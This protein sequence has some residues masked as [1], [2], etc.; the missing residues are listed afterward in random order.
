M[1][2]ALP[3]CQHLADDP[4]TC[5]IPVIIL[6]GMEGPDIVRNARAAGCLFFLRK[7]YDPNALLLLTRDALGLIRPGDLSP[8][9]VGD[10]NGLCYTDGFDFVTKCSVSVRPVLGVAGGNQENRKRSTKDWPQ[11]ATY[12]SSDSP[13]QEIVAVARGRRI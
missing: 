10:V 7:P 1:A 11:E 4:T 12:A 5:Q 3:L 8:D 13:S 9:Q 6:S 2:T